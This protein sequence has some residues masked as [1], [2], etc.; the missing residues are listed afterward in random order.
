MELMIQAY[1]H[2]LKICH[3]PILVYLQTL[4]RKSDR[5]DF[6]CWIGRNG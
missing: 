6:T 5:S 3:P 2:S 4:C 1:T